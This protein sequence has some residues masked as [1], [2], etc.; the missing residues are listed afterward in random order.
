MPR[1]PGWMLPLFVPGAR[2]ERFAR[3]ASCGVDAI[4]ID[5]EDSVAPDDKDLAR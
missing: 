2:P 4:I 3:A 1:H 5:L